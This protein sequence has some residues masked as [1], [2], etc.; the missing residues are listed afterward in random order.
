MV[1]HVRVKGIAW[2]LLTTWVLEDQVIRLGGERLFPPN[3]LDSS[4]VWVLCVHSFLFLTRLY[5]IIPHFDFRD[6]MSQGGSD[7][8]TVCS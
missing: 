7:L 5:K 2:A 3:H 1:L 8:L 4:N 6:G